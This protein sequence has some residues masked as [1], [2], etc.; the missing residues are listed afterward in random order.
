MNVVLEGQCA[1]DAHWWRC[2]HPAAERLEQENLLPD[3]AG[4]VAA[5][6]QDITLKDLPEGQWWWD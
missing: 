2:E 4:K 5:A 1:N 3:E 6:R